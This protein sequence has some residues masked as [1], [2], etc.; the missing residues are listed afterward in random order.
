MTKLV[1]NDGVRCWG[2]YLIVLL[3]VVDSCGMR[4]EDV[5]SRDV[6]FPLGVSVVAVAERCGAAFRRV[7]AQHVRE[8]GECVGLI[9][10]RPELDPIT[11]RL[12]AHVRVVIKLLPD[13]KRVLSRVN[14]SLLEL[15]L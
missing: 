14:G 2:Y 4:H 10:R 8:L 6:G 11:K 13:K 1:Y 3:V 7:Q 15:W 5:V 12:E 9:E